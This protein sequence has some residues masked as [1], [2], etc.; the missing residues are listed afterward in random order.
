M[1]RKR[2]SLTHE[3]Q[4]SAAAR[5]SDRSV[6]KNI[7][8]RP[9][10]HYTPGMRLI[11]HVWEV[12]LWNGCY[13]FHS[14]GML[15]DLRLVWICN[16][17]ATY[18]RRWDTCLN[19]QHVISAGL[20]TWLLTVEWGEWIYL[21]SHTQRRGVWNVCGTLCVSAPN[22]LS[23]IGCWVEQGPPVAGELVV[24]LVVGVVI[25]RITNFSCVGTLG[26]GLLI[27]FHVVHFQHH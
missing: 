6:M 9:W 11:A 5:Y 17:F 23:F 22:P 7:R 16:M 15:T 18:E 26:T 1:R 24:W 4:S 19:P 10:R 25:T 8:V 3:N 12:N 20:F 14:I 2:S 27:C 13:K 21:L